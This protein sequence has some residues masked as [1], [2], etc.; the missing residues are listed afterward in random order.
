MGRFDP[1]RE[2]VPDTPPHAAEDAAPMDI[3]FIEG[4]TGQT[5]IGIDKTE[6]HDAQP[7]RMSLAIGVP[8]LRACTT[9]RIEDTVN[10]A[11]VRD[12]IHV[13]LASHGVQ[14]LEALAEH[15]AQLV[16]AQFGAH[17]VRVSLAKPAKFDDVDA[18]GVVIERRRAPSVKSGLEWIGLGYV[19]Q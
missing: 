6:L 16:I 17:W 15:I 10:Y 12:A 9:D 1:I 13:L 4:L 2:A 8:S 14:L 7:V 11:A 3:V 19:P 18:V 5:V